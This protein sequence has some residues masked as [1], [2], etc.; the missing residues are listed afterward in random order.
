MRFK[1]TGNYL[2]YIFNSFQLDTIFHTL[3]L[4]AKSCYNFDKIL[5]KMQLIKDKLTGE[6]FKPARINQRF[7][8]SK[9]RITFHNE[10]AKVLRYKKASIDKPLHL[11]HKISLELMKEKKEVVFH[12][13]FL[14]GKGFNFGFYT[15]VKEYN[16]KTCF[17]LYN[18]LIITVDNDNIKF[19]K[20]D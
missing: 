4:L 5:F 10:N 2:I 18:F 20:Y 6:L 9:N 7:I 8:T 15:H 1:I 14:L 13:Q 17:A 12:K 19:I 3:I 11:N 16:G